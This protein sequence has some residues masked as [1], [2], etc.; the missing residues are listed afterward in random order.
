[1]DFTEIYKQVFEA[2]F[3]MAVYKIHEMDAKVRQWM[4]WMREITEKV[5]LNNCYS[6]EGQVYEEICV[7]WNAI[8]ADILE[9]MSQRDVVLLEDTVEF[10]VKEFLECFFSEEELQRLRE[11]AING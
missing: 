3:R 2:C 10:G 1:M 6:L 4:P 9:G 8:M 5:I 11:E 7:W